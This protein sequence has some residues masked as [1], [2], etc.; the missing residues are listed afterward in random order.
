MV[1]RVSAPSAS[2]IDI[3]CGDMFGATERMA[4]TTLSETRWWAE[5][6]FRM[7]GFPLCTADDPADPFRARICLLRSVV[8]VREGDLV[9]QD[10]G[11]VSL[12]ADAGVGADLSL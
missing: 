10:E 9:P 7:L 1:S 12:H 11:I 3:D 6:L 8:A 4:R 5:F 2:F